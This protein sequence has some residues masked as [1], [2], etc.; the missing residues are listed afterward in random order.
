MSEAGTWRPSTI[1]LAGGAAVLGAM[2]WWKLSK[3][4]APRAVEMTGQ[5]LSLT[6]PSP[7]VRLQLWASCS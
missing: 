5:V 7:G 3:P 1:W 2:L 4:D 6:A